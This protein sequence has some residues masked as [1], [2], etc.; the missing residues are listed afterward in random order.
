MFGYFALNRLRDRRIA[1]VFLLGMSLWFYGYFN[2][3]YLA[4]ILVSIVI[5]YGFTRLMEKT[6]QQ[7]L[8]K[9]EMILAVLLNIGV[10]FYF[11]YFDFFLMNMNRLFRTDFTLHN[12]L[13]PLGISFFTFQQI[14]YVVDAY[15][16]EVQK[17]GRENI[18]K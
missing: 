6:Q 17:Y 10:L 9:L 7:N 3:S 13:L 1:M 18:A 14:S 4:I 16:G 2:P 11:K 8:R 12:I 15:R 5:N